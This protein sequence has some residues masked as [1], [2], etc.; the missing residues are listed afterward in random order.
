MDGEAEVMEDTSAVATVVAA[1]PELP[2]TEPP[3]ASI[4]VQFPEASPYLY[5]V[6]VE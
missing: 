6:P 1:A 2:L 3:M 4:D 5:A